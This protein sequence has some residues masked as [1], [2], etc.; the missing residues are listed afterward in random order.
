MGYGASR[1]RDAAPAAPYPVA[2]G[3]LHPI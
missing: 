1:G 2:V 3:L